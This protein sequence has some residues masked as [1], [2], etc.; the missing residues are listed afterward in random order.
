MWLKTK[1]WNKHSVHLQRISVHVFLA[2][3][4]KMGYL[5]QILVTVFFTFIPFSSCF[6]NRNCLSCWQNEN[7][8]CQVVNSHI[9][10]LEHPSSTNCN[11]IKWDFLKWSWKSLAAYMLN[12]DVSRGNQSED[13]SAHSCIFSS[14]VQCC[15]NSW[16]NNCC[17]IQTWTHRQPVSSPVACSLAIL[18]LIFRSFSHIWQQSK[19]FSYLI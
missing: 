15:E 8:H 7:L 19:Y 2:V 3:L 16:T 12:V 10:L 18:S 6:W 17:L 5:C 13:V 4:K 9:H 11:Q 1:H 14:S